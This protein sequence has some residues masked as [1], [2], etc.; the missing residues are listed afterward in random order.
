MASTYHQG[1][2]KNGS[3]ICDTSGSATVTSIEK[4]TLQAA[5]VTNVDQTITIPKNSQILA[6]YADSTVAWTA[7]GAVVLTAGITAGGTEYIT[8]IDLK[9]VTRGAPTLTAAQL[10]AMNN[11]GANTSIVFRANSASGANAVGTTIVT[12]LL[13]ITE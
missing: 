12:V 6:I 3:S 11:V 10:L 9:T 5:T 2:I 13:A 8:T 4:V 1:A 7:T